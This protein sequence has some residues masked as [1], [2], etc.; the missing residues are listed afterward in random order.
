MS[1]V[2]DQKRSE[3]EALSAGASIVFYRI[4]LLRYSYIAKVQRTDRKG[5]NMTWKLS[6]K[7]SVYEL[8]G[9]GLIIGLLVL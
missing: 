9:N 3:C 8:N 2:Y 7:F 5:N 6:F 4:K 1:C